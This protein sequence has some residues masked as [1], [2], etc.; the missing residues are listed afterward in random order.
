MILFH[1]AIMQELDID[2]TDINDYAAGSAGSHADAHRSSS[3]ASTPR[4]DGSSL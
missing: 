4:T 2:W 1:R 3:V